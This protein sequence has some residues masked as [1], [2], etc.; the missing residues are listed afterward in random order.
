[1]SFNSFFRA[2]AN[3]RSTAYELKLGTVEMDAT[4]D[5]EWVHRPY[6]NAA[7]KGRTVL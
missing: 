4:A 3:C 1:M 6:S 7:K 5:T 2:I